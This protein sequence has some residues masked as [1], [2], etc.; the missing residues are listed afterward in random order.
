MLLFL[1]QIKRLSTEFLSMS[2]VKDGLKRRSTK[3]VVANGHDGTSDSSSDS[4]DSDGAKKK[5]AAK[6]KTVAKPV[7]AKP[8]TPAKQKPASS[9][10]GEPLIINN[11]LM[12]YSLI[13]CEIGI[14]SAE[15]LSICSCLVHKYKALISTK[16]FQII[17]KC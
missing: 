10:S 17:F 8:P 2:E 12:L 13:L 9:S 3:A 15:L 4:S 1:F 6:T 11:K 16:V 7:T 5:A 14:R